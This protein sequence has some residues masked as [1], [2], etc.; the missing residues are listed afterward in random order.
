MDQNLESSGGIR[1]GVATYVVEAVVAALLLLLGIV[2]AISSWELGAGWTTDG[3]GSG[4]FPFYIGL[5]ICISGA[6]TLFQALFAKNKNTEVFVDGEQLK[7]VLQVLIPA[8]IYVGAIQVFG[9]YVSSA[10]YI[11]LFMVFLGKF[12]PLKAVISAVCV[13]TVFFFMFEVWF[14]VPLFK[15]SIDLLSFLGY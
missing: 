9:I 5:V 4:Y 1:T 11:A 8:A 14:K 13:N 10:V 7:R 2:V 6:G 3:P 12:S 15:G